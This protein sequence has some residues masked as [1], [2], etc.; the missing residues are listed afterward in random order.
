MSTRAKDIRELGNTNHFEVDDNGNV[1]VGTT[2]PAEKLHVDGT[3]KA[4]AFQGDGSQLSGLSGAATEFE[5]HAV[6]PPVGSPGNVYYDTTDEKAYVSNGTEWIPISGS[7]ADPISITSV[8]PTNFSG[9][10]G[11][12]FTIVGTGFTPNT[13]AVF[14]GSNGAEYA[15]GVVTYLSSTGMSI[16]NLNNLPVDNEPFRVKLTEGGLSVSSTQTI[17]AGSVPS[18]TTP[19][20]RLVTTSRWDEAIDTAVVASD[21][22]GAIT[23]YAVSAGSLPSGIELNATTGAITGTSVEQATT[24]H[25]FEVEATDETGNTNSRQYEIQIQNAAPVWNSPATNST[26]EAS[27]DSAFSLLLDAT[28]PEGEAVSYSAPSLPAGLSLSGNTISG[29]PTVSANDSVAITASDGFSSSVNNFFINVT[30]PPLILLFGNNAT[31]PSSVSQS[32]DFPAGTVYYAVMG[33]GGSGAGTHYQGGGSG[34]G[35]HGSFSWSGGVI[36][37]V[38]GGRSGFDSNTSNTNLKGIDGK[39]TL[40]VNAANNAVLVDADGGEGGGSDTAEANG[41]SGGGGA[42]NAG[43]GGPG[44][45]GGTNGGNGTQYNGGNGQ[46]TAFASNFYAAITSGLTAHGFSSINVSS[47]AGGA[48]STGSHQGGGGGGGV[49]ISYSGSPSNPSGL[50]PTTTFSGHTPGQGGNGWGGGGGASGYSGGRGPTGNGAA[51]FAILWM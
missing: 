41:F 36:N 16:T 30:Q 17:D 18:F 9:A 47:G 28:D 25:T 33:G 19:A 45:T 32:Q 48:Q 44:G 8:D 42:G 34:F 3:V 29:T 6:A 5:T 38:V 26:Q 39:N 10:A 4:T 11:T 37:A 7:T 43:T 49:L 24:T 31:S 46:G 21:A 13:T 50:A 35:A 1:G 23:G 12:S 20:G 51:G 15:T 27:Q 22:D 2:S 40:I 14:T